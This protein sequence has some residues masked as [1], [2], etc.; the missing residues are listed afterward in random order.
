M[1]TK[2][3]VE[4]IKELNKRIEKNNVLRTKTE[5]Q[6]EMLKKDLSSQINEYKRKYG[7]D[8]H[9]KS[10]KETAGN[11]SSE[12]KAT[13]D[14]VQEEYELK[15]KVV[16][17]IESGDI[18]LASKLLGMEVDETES[19]EEP[20]QVEESVK[21]VEEKSTKKEIPQGMTPAEDIV[22]EDDKDDDIV[23]EDDVKL[24]DTGDLEVEDDD[25]ED[26]FGLGFGKE[27]SG[28]SF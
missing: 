3:T 23:I 6:I 25:E 8:L 13:V 12:A 1:A 24:S 11:I 26:P 4:S 9:G 21:D 15:E 18:A 17:A 22:V 14:A 2:V 28:I 16:H 19:A 7:V 27:F 5:T 10:F 20:E